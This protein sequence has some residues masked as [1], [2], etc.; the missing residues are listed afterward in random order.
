MKDER[1]KMKGE[2]GKVKGEREVERGKGKG[3][4]DGEMRRERRESVRRTPLLYEGEG[5]PKGG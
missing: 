3:K 1:G 4:S 2:R 5:T